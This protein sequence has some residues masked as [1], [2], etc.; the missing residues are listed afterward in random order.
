MR[1]IIIALFL[2]SSCATID[3][4]KGN[5]KEEQLYPDLVVNPKNIINLNLSS[6]YEEAE[7]VCNHS[8]SKRIKR[9]RKKFSVIAPNKVGLYKCVVKTKKQGRF[10]SEGDFRILVSTKSSP[11]IIVDIDHTIADVSSLK[12]LVSDYKE[13]RELPDAS[14]YLN[15]LAKKYQVIYLTARNDVFREHT[16]KWLGHNNFP[17]GPVLF[18][19]IKDY[20]FFD[21]E[22]KK[23]R[24]SMVKDKISNIKFAVGDKD[25]DITAY[26]FNKL[27]TI[28]IRKDFEAQKDVTFVRSWNDI[29]KMFY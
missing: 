21:S 14:K 2:L 8:F 18:W 12:F 5:L 1:I 11:S 19:T 26:T 20:P 15:L 23:L 7:I 28:I 27:N 4:S 16:M 3:S 6:D 17:E 29:Y 10:Y 24:V 9:I 25:S 13:I 22:Y